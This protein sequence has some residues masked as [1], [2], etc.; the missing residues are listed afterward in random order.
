VRISPL[1]SPSSQKKVSEKIILASGSPRRIELLSRITSNFISIPSDVREEA[2]GTPEEQVLT[3]AHDKVHEVARQEEGI[4]IGA[5]TLV[6]L[7]GDILEKPH[8]RAEAKGMLERLSNH[9]HVVL[10]GLY[11]LK[12]ESGEHKETVEK[13][14]VRFRTL[15][16]EEIEA[17]LK[18]GEYVDKAG[19]YAI[20]GRAALFVAGIIGDY[21]NV[22]GLPLCRLAL[23]LKE[24]GVEL[25]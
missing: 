11:V 12:T 14:T 15:H 20:Q 3:L 9:E 19:A 18:T 13:T 25:P 7:D 1:S 22:M 23:L 21:F 24:I 5:D 10:T 17:Y 4:I 6:V 8:S 2:S 16:N